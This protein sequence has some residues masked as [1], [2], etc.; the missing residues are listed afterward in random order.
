MG[1]YIAEVVNVLAAL[2]AY[3]TANTAAIKKYSRVEKFIA[4]YKVF[5]DTKE[6]RDKGAARIAPL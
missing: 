2:K 1:A 6:F 3:A 5:K 4:N